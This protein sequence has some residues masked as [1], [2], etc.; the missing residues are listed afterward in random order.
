[1]PGLPDRGGIDG[2]SGEGDPL[3]RPC[4][5]LRSGPGHGERGP[6]LRVGLDGHDPAARTDERR[7]QLA[8]SGP[9]VEDELLLRSEQP[10]D[11]LR[12]VAGPVAPVGLGDTAE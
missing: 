3:G 2:G 10:G 12:R 1:M 11:G 5:E 9:E 6:H 7:R 4:G 8:R